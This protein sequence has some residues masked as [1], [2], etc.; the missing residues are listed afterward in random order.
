MATE[1]LYFFHIQTHYSQSLEC[2]YVPTQTLHSK[3]ALT[4]MTRLIRDCCIM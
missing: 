2:F 3:R 1:D 4:L